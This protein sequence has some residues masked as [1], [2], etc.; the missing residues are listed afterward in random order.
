MNRLF[1][2][3]VFTSVFAVVYYACFVFSY[4]PVRFYPLMGEISTQDLPRTAGPAMGWF[5]W[6]VIGSVAGLVAGIA[7]LLAPKNMHERIGAHLSWIVPAGVV[8]WMLWVEKH[9]FM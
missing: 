7:A 5:T 4:T 9:W 1:P 6:I 2:L 3:A 8:V